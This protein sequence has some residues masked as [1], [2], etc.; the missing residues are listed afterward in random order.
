MALQRRSRAT[1]AERARERGPLAA[2]VATRRL[3]LGLTQADLADLAGVA[4]GPVVSLEAGRTVSLDVLTSVL[5]VLGLH[6]EL[7]RGASP[8]GLEVSAPLAAQYGLGQKAET[9]GD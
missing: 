9:A 8:D 5:L 3:E 4:L 2:V 1:P 7:T 6:L